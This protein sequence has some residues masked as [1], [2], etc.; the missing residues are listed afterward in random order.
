MKEYSQNISSDSL[1][2][3]VHCL[4]HITVSNDR[5][6]QTILPA[7]LSL[8]FHFHSTP[9]ELRARR[10][11]SLPPAEHRLIDNRLAVPDYSRPI[12]RIR[13]M[14]SGW[15]QRDFG[16]PAA[17]LLCPETLTLIIERRVNKSRRLL[18]LLVLLRHGS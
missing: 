9:S 17:N 18:H 15:P 13:R 8:K 4:A 3:R 12:P 5:V 11:A 10:R 1:S 6:T 2:S 7:W 16:H 14:L